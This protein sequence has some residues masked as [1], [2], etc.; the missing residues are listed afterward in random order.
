MQ[1]VSGLINHVHQRRVL[2]QYERLSVVHGHLQR[3]RD[4]SLRALAPAQIFGARAMRRY[5]IIAQQLSP[6]EG[7][8]NIAGNH[9]A[10]DM[11]I[12]MTQQGV[13]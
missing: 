7:T 13:S 1:W 6:L 4:V 2:E 12:S 11:S 8:S 3:H 9:R 10:K 5:A